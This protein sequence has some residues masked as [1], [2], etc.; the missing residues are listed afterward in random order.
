MHYEG[1]ELQPHSQPVS[2]TDLQEGAFYFAVNYV[3]EDMLIPIVETLV[4]IGKNLK[5]ADVGKAYFQDV[6]AQAQT[7][8]MSTTVRTCCWI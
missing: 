2:G 5:P 4:F 6:E 7:S 1:R 8:D 3:D